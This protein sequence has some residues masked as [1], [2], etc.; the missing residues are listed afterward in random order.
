[1][2]TCFDLAGAG[3]IDRSHPIARCLRDGTLLSHHAVANEH[4][5]DA[6]GQVRLGQR[7]D[8]PFV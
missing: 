2:R 4:T 3:A 1:V 6:L 7:G 5:F 8:S